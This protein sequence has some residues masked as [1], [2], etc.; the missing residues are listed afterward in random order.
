MIK[1]SKAEDYA[2]ILIHTLVQS[3]SSRLVP[4][5]EVAKKYSLSILFLRNIAQTLRKAHIITATEGKSG[6]YSLVKDP[7]S[8]TI[9][10][11]MTAVSPKPILECC[12]NHAKGDTCGKESFCKPGL[13]WRRINKSFLDT[14]Y[15][16]SISDFSKNYA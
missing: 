13:A 10:E 8:I 3:Y 16:V 1:F 12:S 6:G 2:L 15:K 5:S 9:G 14:V 4:L 7:Q 11:V